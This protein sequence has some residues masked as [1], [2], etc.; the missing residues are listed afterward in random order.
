[1]NYENFRK[2]SDDET[3]IYKLSEKVKFSDTIPDKRLN[4]SQIGLLAIL[5]SCVVPDKKFKAENFSR[6]SYEDVSVAA[7]NLSVLEKYGYVYRV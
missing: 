1:M 4:L 2:E 5:L 6:Y 7:A 3:P